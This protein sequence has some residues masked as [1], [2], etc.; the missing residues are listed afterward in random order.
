MSNYLQLKKSN[1]RN[2]YKCIRH[3]PVKSIRFS[4]NQA[5]IVESECI[6]CG[7]CYV[8][9]PQNA[10]VIVSEMEK[11]KMFLQEDTPVIA[12]IAPSFLANFTDVGI[13]SMRAGLIE[14]GFTDV[15]ETAIGATIVKRK[16]D[17]MLMDGTHNVLISSSCHS[18]NLLIQKH[19]STL[20]HHLADVVS[21]MQAHGLD[22]KR[23]FPDARVVF[24]GPCIAKKDEAAHYEGIIDGVLTFEEIGKWLN[25]EEIIL[26]REVKDMENSKARF[27]PISGGILK[28]MERKAEDYSYIAID[29]EKNCIAALRDIEA[30]KI[31]K[32]FIEM[33]MC[34]GSCIGGP[35]MKDEHI[36]SISSYISVKK[37]AGENDFHVEDLPCDEVSKHLKYIPVKYNMPSKVELDEILINMGKINPEDQLNCGSCGYDSCINKAIAVYQNKADLTMCLPFLS[38]KAESFSDNIFNNTPNG[39]LVLNENLEIQQI[40]K[41][42]LEIL[43]IAD[44]SFVMGE[45]CGRILD[46]SSFIKVLDEGENYNERGVYLVDYGKYVDQTIIYDKEYHIIICIMRDITSE[47][48]IKEKKDEAS[49]KT[50]DIADRVVERQMK[51]VQEIASLLGETAAETKI[52]LTKLKEV[53]V[54]E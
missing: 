30:G 11:I 31:N 10:K 29:G 50:A 45:N 1:C 14:L 5:H 15:E 35:V 54:D 16:Y 6:L 17:K 28:S 44:E 25:D 42:A 27:F 19:F 26:K 22:I 13:E 40:N 9:C 7:K 38:G 51:V 49:R 20:L 32:C 52:A 12:S 33:S 3:C 37:S 39:L 2:C 23:R 47:I 46:P 43:N 21:P 48:K 53:A 4:G 34:N 8:V 18:V 24:I 41:S 36:G